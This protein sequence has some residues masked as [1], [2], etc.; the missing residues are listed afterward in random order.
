MHTI[1]LILFSILFITTHCVAQKD[2]RIF[3]DYSARSS[4]E[5]VTG[6]RNGLTSK[7]PSRRDRAVI[8]LS[9]LINNGKK[10]RK[11]H[12]MV[13]RLTENKE[14]V[15]IAADIVAERLVGWYE[16]RESAQERSMPMYYPL[17]HLL[18]ISKSKTAAITLIMAQPIVGFDPFFRKSVLSNEL[19]LR[20][21]LS[22]LKTIENKLCCSY[23]GKDPVAD[24]LAIDLRLNMLRMYLEAAKD[25]KGSGF[26]SNDI[27]MKSFVS[28]CLEFG[29]GNKGRIVRTMAVELACILIKAGQKDFLPAVKRITK[30]DPCYLYRTGP[31]ESNSL[32]QYDIN[33]KYYPVREKAIKELSFLR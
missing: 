15:N 11:E 20:I 17:I 29:D 3:Q 14:T 19:A 13:L 6:I 23:P 31:A 22:K 10:S 25:K 28:G 2:Y 4:E 33:N 12:E 26:L 8:F 21:V 27:K 1:I 5:I 18:S 30:S 32:P 24:M 9:I 16:E 7:D